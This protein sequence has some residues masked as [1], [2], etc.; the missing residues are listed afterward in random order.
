MSAILPLCWK[1]TMFRQTPARLALSSDSGEPKKLHPPLRRSK[2]ARTYSAK[3]VGFCGSWC[4]QPPV[5]P[6]REVEWPW[7][8]MS[9]GDRLPRLDQRV[10]H[11]RSAF[12]L[13]SS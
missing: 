13:T 8:N 3:L 1:W 6:G 11:K 7:T 9:G 2:A 4:P 10:D 12:A 5:C